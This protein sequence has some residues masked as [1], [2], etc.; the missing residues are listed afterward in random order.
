MWGES[1]GSGEIA[2]L[3]LQVDVSIVAGACADD[4]TTK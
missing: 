3:L 1:Q 2:M 4:P